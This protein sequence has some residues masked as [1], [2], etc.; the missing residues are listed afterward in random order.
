MIM[1]STAEDSRP[2]VTVTGI[3]GYLGSHVTLILL[4]EGKYRV[5]GTVRSKTNAEK[6]D[7]IRNAFG[8]DL[9]DQLELVEADLLDNDSIARAIQGS[10]YVVHVASPFMVEDPADEMELI[11]PAVEGTRSVMQAAY[12]AGVK[13]ICLTSSMVSCMFVTGPDGAP[14]EVIDES[15][16]SDPNAPTISA[17]EKSKT[18]AER[19]A[20]DFLENCQT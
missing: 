11:R 18:L 9:F 4:R 1:V 13:R 2:V 19:A 3:T 20:W 12:N 6:L 15:L 10:T 16:W 8:Q 14:P 17:Y 5:R 7:P